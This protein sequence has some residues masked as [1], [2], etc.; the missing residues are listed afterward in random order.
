VDHYRA[1]VRR[2][3]VASVDAR[4]ADTRPAPASATEDT[5]SNLAEIA[6]CLRPLIDRLPDHSRRA[7]ERVELH[8]F[9]QQAAADLEGLSLSGMKAR[10]QRAR[11]Q[12]KV[13]LLEC[14]R[15]ALDRR[16]GVFGCETRD[17]RSG[18]CSRSGCHS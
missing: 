1:P 6:G 15:I 18:A 16:G 8:G 2:I 12:L 17:N 11:A 7:I 5:E 9:S 14:C 13:A 4:E 10:V 3:E